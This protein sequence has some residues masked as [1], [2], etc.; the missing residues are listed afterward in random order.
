MWVINRSTLEGRK[1]RR[2]E[3]G[4]EEEREE[5]EGVRWRKRKE[6]RV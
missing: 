4:G 5:E 1:E 2:K 3:G 6:K